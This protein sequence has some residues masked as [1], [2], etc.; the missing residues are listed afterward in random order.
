MKDKCAFYEPDLMP[1]LNSGVAHL[2]FGVSI[3]HSGC[4]RT[5][6]ANHNSVLIAAK[7]LHNNSF[8]S[9]NKIFDE[10]IKTIQSAKRA[11]CAT[12]ISSSFQSNSKKY[13]K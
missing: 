13:S 2:Y 10:N 1:R 4:I 5:A 3:P 6:P 8:N 12:V 7:L 11:S 9:L